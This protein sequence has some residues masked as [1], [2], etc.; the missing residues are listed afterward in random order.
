M[1][2]VYSYLLLLLFPAFASHASPT[3]DDFIPCK[4]ISVYTLKACLE[5]NAGSHKDI[6]QKESK[7]AYERCREKVFLSYAPIHRHPRK[8]AM[9]YAE[10]THKLQKLA[11]RTVNEIISDV[12]R[13]K[14]LSSVL[15]RSRHLSS[16]EAYQV[17]AISRWLGYFPGKLTKDACMKG[18]QAFM[19]DYAIPGS[20][21]IWRSISEE[22]KQF[23]KAYRKVCPQWAKRDGGIPE[24]N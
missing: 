2:K 21:Y 24:K 3:S 16:R 19:S 1:M 10:L 20:E 15:K 8:T 7:A 4:K 18:G 14:S 11:S 6:C 22:Q 23:W 5:K 17:R 12:R 9:A 13:M